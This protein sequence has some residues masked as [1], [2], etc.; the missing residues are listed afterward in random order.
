MRRYARLI[1]VSVIEPTME[2]LNYRARL[3]A[4]RTS[5]ADSPA[6]YSLR[7]GEEILIGRHIIE[8]RPWS[9][10]LAYLFHGLKVRL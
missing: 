6:L 10:L 4:S 7:S 3:C 2:T 9:R 5:I 1:C 8:N